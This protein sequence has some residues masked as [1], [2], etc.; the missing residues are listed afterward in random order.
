MDMIAEMIGL[1]ENFVNAA[2]TAIRGWC[3]FSLQ[4][5]D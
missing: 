4:E 3:Y 2:P 5:G 1:K